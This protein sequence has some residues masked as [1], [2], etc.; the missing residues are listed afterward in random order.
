MAAAVTQRYYASAKMAQL[1]NGYYNFSWSGGT[2][3]V[4]LRDGGVFWCPAFPAQATWAYSPE[5]TTLEI[6]WGKYGQYVLRVQGDELV[7]GVRGNEADWRKASFKRAF[8]PTEALVSG[9]AWMLHFENGVPFRIEFRAD[10]H[11]HCESYPGHFSYR[12]TDDKVAL[13]WGK[14]G[15]YDFTVDVNAKQ[16]N[17]SLRGNAASWRRAEYIEPVA[18][19]IKSTECNHSH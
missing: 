12:I 14:Y 18:A 17:G 19:Y 6:D 4:Q 9:S 1:Q 15:S 8:T 16:M 5:T 13:E 11:F 10:G 3:D 2:F 7:G